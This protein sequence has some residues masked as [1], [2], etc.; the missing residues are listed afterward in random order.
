[1]GSGAQWRT[2]VGASRGPLAA[3]EL[4]FE[5]IIVERSIG[6]GS[7]G[8]V[9]K[10]NWKS[11][12]VAVKILLDSGAGDEETDTISALMASNSPIL[13]RLEQEASIMTLMHHPN[14]GKWGRT[15]ELFCIYVKTLLKGK[16]SKTFQGYLRTFTLLF[17]FSLAQTLI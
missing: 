8:H 9:Y 7:W 15:F 4:R 1:M 3:W 6:Q 12:P 13:E 14:I 11:T 17:N 5:D 16:G 10:G 2:A